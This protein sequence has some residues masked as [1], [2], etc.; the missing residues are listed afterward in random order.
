MDAVTSVRL[1][2]SGSRVSFRQA[3]PSAQVER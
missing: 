3:D 1:R 2:E